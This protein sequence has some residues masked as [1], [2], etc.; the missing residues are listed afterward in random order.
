[1]NKYLNLNPHQRKGII[2]AGGSGTRF[3]AQPYLKSDYGQYLLKV[4]KEQ[5]T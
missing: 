2:L 5:M 4:S 1:M 3:M